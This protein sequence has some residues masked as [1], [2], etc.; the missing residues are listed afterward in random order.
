MAN[1]QQLNLAA[2]AQ[3]LPLHLNAPEVF[4]GMPHTQQQATNRPT[5]TFVEITQTPT[6]THNL[7]AA[8]L[9][10]RQHDKLETRDNAPRRLATNLYTD[11]ELIGTS[12]ERYFNAR[13]DLKRPR[14]WRPTHQRPHPGPR[15]DADEWYQCNQQKIMNKMAIISARMVQAREGGMA[16]SR[17]HGR[18]TIGVPKLGQSD[19]VEF[20]LIGPRGLHDELENIYK[21]SNAFVQNIPQPSGETWEWTE[22]EKKSIAEM[23]FEMVMRDELDLM[24]GLTGVL[25]VKWDQPVEEPRPEVIRPTEEKHQSRPVKVPKPA[26][27][28]KARK[29]KPSQTPQPAREQHQQKPQPEQS[30]PQKPR[31][32]EPQVIEP[33]RPLPR[34]WQQPF[35]IRELEQVEQPQQ[36]DPHK[37]VR[38]VDPPQEFEQPEQVDPHRP[39][40]PVELPPYD[41]IEQ[42]KTEQPQ[43]EQQRPVEEPHQ[44][45]NRPVE[46]TL[47]AQDNQPTQ[48]SEP[49]EEEPEP[50]EESQSTEETQST[51]R[52]LSP[53]PTR[54][55]LETEF[56]DSNGGRPPRSNSILALVAALVFLLVIR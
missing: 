47:P 20:H 54:G 3:P 10:T 30:Q 42:P 35:P 38:P 28:S 34:P 5:T 39:V 24:N 45:D 48:T 7:P 17:A 23:A 46:T 49:V 52:P 8:T 40:E 6:T 12:P 21:G 19:P 53:Q 26:K 29:P 13:S 44:V 51:K 14:E 55:S 2:V 18:K 9:E 36:V 22:E 15:S 11:E 1:L 4:A 43:A 32:E 37:P 27:T 56:P 25:P 16:Q 50:A 41:F 33:L 31:P